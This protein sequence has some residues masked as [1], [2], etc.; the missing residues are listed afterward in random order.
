M[1]PS[2]PGCLHCGACLLGVHGSIK[3]NSEFYGN[4]FTLPQGLYLQNFVDAW[5][6]ARMGEYFM[7]SVMITAMS[8]AILLLVALPA[9]MCS[10]ATTSSAARSS[11]A[12]SWPA[13]SST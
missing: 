10:A 2:S 9:A 11:A 1:W 13:C 3:Q 4:P 8:L 5:T 12:A 6:K 7:T